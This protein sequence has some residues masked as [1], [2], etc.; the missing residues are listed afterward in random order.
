MFLKFCWLLGSGQP[1]PKKQMR[2]RL[3][4]WSSSS[5]APNECVR[6]AGAS[7]AI[8]EGCEIKCSNIGLIRSYARGSR[9]LVEYTSFADRGRKALA[10]IK[11]EVLFTVGAAGQGAPTGAHEGKVAGATCRRRVSKTRRF[12]PR[13]VSMEAPGGLP[14][15]ESK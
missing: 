15:R 11:A 1:L 7:W 10:G 14:N 13:L 5:G 6:A 12:H 4:V 2:A 3:D 8:S 9:G